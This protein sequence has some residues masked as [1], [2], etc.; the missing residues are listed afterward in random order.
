[1]G[2]THYFPQKKSFT[3]EQWGKV[4]EGTNKILAF[5][6]ERG[7][8]LKWEYTSSKDPEVSEDRVRFNGF[9]DEGHETFLV[10]KVKAESFNFCKTAYKPYDLAVC[11]TL[12]L[13]KDVAPG[14]LDVSSDG[15]DEDWKEANEAYKSLFESQG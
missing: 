1:M 2:Y 4:M 10:P 15:G 13:M 12:L 7:I 9:G 8:A 14:V 6:H 5:C 11:M 3:D